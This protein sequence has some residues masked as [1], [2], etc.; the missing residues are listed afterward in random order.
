MMD[1]GLG[2]NILE[3]ML[4]VFFWATLLVLAI[5]LLGWLFPTVTPSNQDHSKSIKR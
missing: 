3:L 5:W 2:M 1:F 4:L